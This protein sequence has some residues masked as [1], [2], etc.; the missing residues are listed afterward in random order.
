MDSIQNLINGVPDGFVKF[1]LIV[2]FALL[3]G[4][5]QRSRFGSEN[6][7]SYFGTDRTHALIGVLG[8][9]L[10]N[11]NTI[12]L[13]PFLGGG[14]LLGIILAVYY[15][16]KIATEK[17]DG[18]TAIIVALITYCLAP[19]VYTQPP[20]M[21]VLL[22]VTILIIVEIKKPLFEFSKKVDSREFITLAKFLI[23]AGVILPLLPDRSISPVF[24]FS[25]Y[26]FWMAI[27]AVSGISYGSYILKKFVFPQSGI[28]LSGI[29]GGLYSSTATTFILARK[30]KELNENNKIT[31]AIILATSMM[32]IRIFALS[33]L[34]N[35][36]IAMKIAPA[37]GVLLVVSVLVA[38]YM[39]RLD[40][41][42]GKS[43]APQQQIEASYGNPLEFKTAIVFGGLF[44]FFAVLTNYVTNK[45]GAQGIQILSYVVGV[46]DIDP[47]IIN[48]FQSKFALSSTVLAGAVV[49]AVTSNNILKMIYALVLSDKSIRKKI[50]VGFGLIIVLGIGASFLINN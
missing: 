39:L 9:I 23:M 47:F 45:F 17:Q 26:K 38:V 49:N 36:T 32:F 6:E 20:W 5:E 48:I 16:N 29:L 37:F 46:T 19:L 21:V 8:F 43:N 33:L 4:L 42:K 35:K 25:P 31:A 7:S 10:Y 27:V 11:L 1:L 30:S 34:F 22:V 14:L 13:V 18:I 3:I 50:S 24:N 44:I 2:V 12:S 41:A 40:K 15:Q 28:V